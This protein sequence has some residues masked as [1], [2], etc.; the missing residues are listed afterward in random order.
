MKSH[1]LLIQTALMLSALAA[2]SQGTMIYDQQSATN[3]GP[4]GGDAGAPIGWQQPMGQSFTPALSAIGFVQF[5]FADPSR[6]DGVG[7]TVYVNVLADSISGTVLAS[8]TPVLMPDGFFWGTTSFFFSAPVSVTP[9]TT[10]YL[11]PVVLSGDPL[12]DVIG[13][14]YGYP[15]GTFYSSGAPS[16]SGLDLWFREGVIIP[17]PQSGPLVLLGIAG[18]CAVRR[19][20]RFRARYLATILVG[21]LASAGAASAQLQTG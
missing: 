20:R 5:K 3:Q 9:D 7:A 4:A 15:G 13:G 16:S 14:N 17:E 18:I 2:Y 10:Y 19:V 11:Q 1:S 12:W 6:G 21:L 8:T